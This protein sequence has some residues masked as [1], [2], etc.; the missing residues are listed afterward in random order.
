MD[1]GIEKKKGTAR[2]E[3][4]ADGEQEEHKALEY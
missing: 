3:K 2:G 1:M 4:T